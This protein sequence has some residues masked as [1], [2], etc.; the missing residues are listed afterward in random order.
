MLLVCRFVLTQFNSNALN[1]HIHTCYP[2][3]VVGSA[4][5]LPATANAR[6]LLLCL[7]VI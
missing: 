4:H 2:P 6:L 5:C 3:G 1:T 7:T